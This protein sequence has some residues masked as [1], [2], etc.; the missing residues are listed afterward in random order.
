VPDSNTERS[1]RGF[2][3][4]KGEAVVRLRANVE[5][6]IHSEGLIPYTD[7]NQ[8]WGV[9]RPDGEKVIKP[10]SR[11]RLITYFSNGYAPFFD[12]SYW[13]VVAADGEI[14]VRA[15][16]GATFVS[17]DLVGVKDNEKFGF[18]NLKGDEVIRPEFDAAMPFF[19]RTAIVKEGSRWVLIDRRGKSVSKRDFEE[20]ANP[21]EQLARYVA[22][23]SVASD[24]FDAGTVVGSLP[25][26]DMSD[27]KFAGVPAWAPVAELMSTLGLA[28]SQLPM[29][30]S[31]IALAPQRAA[32][33][34]HQVTVIFNEAVRQFFSSSPNAGARAN[35][36]RLQ[37]DLQGK[38][39]GRGADVADLIVNRLSTALQPQRIVKQ[40]AVSDKNKVL[41]AND[42]GEYIVAV[43]ISPNQVNVQFQ[44]SADLMP[45]GGS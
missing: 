41:F 32:W 28:E 45:T 35:G 40:D 23:E 42:K 21:A 44:F 7:G 26:S 33:G 11:F 5:Y 1:T 15:K 16:Y 36:V 14:A 3:N 9:M 22:G 18:I 4:K 8:E 24:F 29:N 19:G 27:R 2:I 34:Q 31:Q 25:L 6:G 17:G 20:I 13:G 10:S 12:G 43:V 39:R 30:Q 38:G 37:I